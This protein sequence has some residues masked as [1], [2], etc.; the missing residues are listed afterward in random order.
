MK[1][2][3]AEIDALG[4]KGQAF[5][6]ADGS[7]SYPIADA[8]DLSNAIHAVGRGGADHDDIRKY[9]VGRAKA[10]G[11]SNK[12]PPNWGADGSMRS[13][14]RES[15]LRQV[16]FMAEPSDGNT[17]EGYAAVF[18]QP[19]MIDSRSEG[20]FRERMEPGAFAKTIRERKP[21]MM[22]DHG[23]HPMVGSIPIGAI[24]DLR[25]DSHGLYV[26]ADLFPNSL[27]E[28][29]RD[30][31]KGGA[32][33][34]MSI[35]MAVLRDNWTVGNDHMSERSVKEVSLAELGPVVFPAYEGTS[36]TARAQRALDG[37]ADTA[38]RMEIARIL[39]TDID[40]PASLSAAAMVDAP[41]IGHPSTRSKA[42][43]MAI[44][45]R[46]FYRK[47]YQ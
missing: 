20:T 23:Q 33:S 2:T 4:A 24:T 37:L 32:I 45:Q 10:L 39:G 26:K 28:P 1:Y 22:F 13:S 46:H 44:R 7:Y 41:T 12:I 27:V 19:A 25:E 47:D 3:Q 31:I 9:I 8:E 35:R 15:V 21:V 18:N 34:G 29:V 6:N 40:A 5:K 14:S 16:D 42:Q 43:R 38:V 36:V 17:L 30:A 11:L